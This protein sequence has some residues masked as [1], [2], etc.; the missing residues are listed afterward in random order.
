MMRRTFFALHSVALLFLC[1]CFSRPLCEERKA[2]EK[3]RLLT[4]SQILIPCSEEG[5]SPER[6]YTEVDL[7]GD[8]LNEIIISDSVTMAGTGGIEW[9]L[10]RAAAPDQYYA[11]AFHF[12][13]AISCLAVE[14]DLNSKVSGKRL[15]IYWHISSK[16]GIIGYIFVN[17]K[18]GF[19]LS[20]VLEIFPGGTECGQKIADAV[21]TP[22]SCLKVKSLGKGEL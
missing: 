19:E 9:S 10:Y 21:F 8:G 5:L 14:E 18:G 4:K 12:D 17:D 7:T 11:K 15:W 3:D 6:L 1:S 16:D 22:E 2:E 13:S 20:P